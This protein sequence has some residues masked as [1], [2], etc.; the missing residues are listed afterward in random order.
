MVS[1]GSG[2]SNAG[3]DSRG[4]AI[5][6]TGGDSANEAILTLNGSVGFRRAYAWVTFEKRLR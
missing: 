6:K 5:A 4:V 3:R 1:P 2:G